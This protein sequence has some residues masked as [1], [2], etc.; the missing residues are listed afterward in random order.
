MLEQQSEILSSGDAFG[1]FTTIPHKQPP[2]PLP[3]GTYR[4]TIFIEFLKSDQESSG[5][6]VIFS[7][8]MAVERWVAKHSSR[9]TAV[10]EE[11]VVN[12]EGVVNADMVAKEGVR[13]EERHD[14]RERI[15]RRA[16]LKKMVTVV[17]CEIYTVCVCFSNCTVS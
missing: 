8:K 7:D 12:G 1:F 10:S 2:P 5:E 11:V 15:L 3:G 9:L 16:K 14:L 6:D 4:R 13:A 17:A